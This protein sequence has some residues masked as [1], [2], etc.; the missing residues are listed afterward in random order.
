MKISELIDRLNK[1]K[2]THG[3]LEVKIGCP[4]EYQLYASD[5]SVVHRNIEL[6]Q[7]FKNN[8]K[9]FVEILAGYR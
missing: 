8:Q 3:N 7:D 1:I 6:V 5:I 9:V 4:E 2:Q